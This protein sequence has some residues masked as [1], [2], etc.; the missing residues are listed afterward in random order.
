MNLDSRIC[1]RLE[2]VKCRVLF[3]KRRSNVELYFYWMMNIQTRCKA[4][5]LFNELYQNHKTMS[6]LNKNV[7]SHKNTTFYITEAHVPLIL[8]IVNLVNALSKQTWITSA[9]LGHG[10]EDRSHRILRNVSTYTCARYLIIIHIPCLPCK[11]PIPG[12]NR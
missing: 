10:W 12:S 8:I 2:R 5:G 4:I 6:V 7:M 9:C 3:I 11:I 1:A